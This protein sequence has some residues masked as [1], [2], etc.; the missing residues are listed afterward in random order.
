MLKTL[1][2]LLVMQTAGEIG[3]LALALP[4]PGPV[5]GMMLLLGWL[6]VRRPAADELRPTASELLRHLSLLF[7]PAGVGVMLHARRLLDEGWA[8]GIALVASTALA[9]VATALTVDRVRRWIGEPEAAA[10]AGDG[11][12][13]AGGDG[14]GGAR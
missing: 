8:I 2:T 7:V 1:A 3:S 11:A 10:G 4:I 12:G 6:A 9:L 14:S 13:A 5:L